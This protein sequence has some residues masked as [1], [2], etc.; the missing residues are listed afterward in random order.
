MKIYL[1]RHG[2]TGFNQKKVYHGW[3]NSLLSAA[4]I[5]QC[6]VLRG[7]LTEIQFDAIISSPLERALHSAEI[8]T[9]VSRDAIRVC[10]GLKEFN[11]GLWE[12]RHYQDIE[13][14]HPQEWQAW[15]RDWLNFCLPEGESFQVFYQRV[16]KCF[17]EIQRVYRDKT[18]LVVSHEGPLR[19]I[20]GLIMNL[21]PEDYWRFGFEFGCYSL[22][23]LGPG[24]SAVKK[25]NC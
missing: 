15:S 25:I 11:F 7:K 2:E 23:E 12:G 6:H 21:R 9:E 1:T 24:V 19:I 13:R 18:I 17:E 20:A 10:E 3:T 22:F 14:N 16:K 8:I 4:G 5:N